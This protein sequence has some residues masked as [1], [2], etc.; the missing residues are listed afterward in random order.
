MPTIIST[1]TR[2]FGSASASA[3]TLRKPFSRRTR[4][5]QLLTYATCAISRRSARAP[6]SNRSRMWSR[7]AASMPQPMRWQNLTIPAAKP[8]HV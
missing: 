6:A 7:T 1:G 4:A 5:V 8:W 2:S 3:L